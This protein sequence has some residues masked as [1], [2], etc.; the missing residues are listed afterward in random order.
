M[1]QGNPTEWRRVFDRAERT[2]RPPLER[3]ANSPEFYS[4]L[5]TA[6]RLHRAVS[7]RTDQ[8]ASW[9]LHLAGL[10]SGLDIKDL[11]RQIGGLQQEV[12]ALRRELAER[13]QSTEDEP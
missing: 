4:L 6:Q 9:A 5:V 13:E 11:G 12:G 1:S 7:S 8:L 2:V 10:P 3:A